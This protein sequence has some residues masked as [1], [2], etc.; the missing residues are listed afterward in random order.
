MLTYSVRSS[1]KVDEEKTLHSCMSAALQKSADYIDSLVCEEAVLPDNVFETSASLG[2]ECLNM[3]LFDELLKDMF[4]TVYLRSVLFASYKHVHAN[5]MH[6]KH[7]AIFDSSS[8]SLFPKF[9]YFCK[10]K[11]VSITSASMIMDGDF[12][13]FGVIASDAIQS[14]ISFINDLWRP[15][16]D[17]DRSAW[18]S[19]DYERMQEFFRARAST[20]DLLHQVVREGSSGIKL[21]FPD[22]SL[23]I[24]RIPVH[25]DA[26][27][28]ELQGI[29]IAMVASWC[30]QIDA[31][32]V[33]NEPFFHDSNFSP[34]EEILYWTTRFDVLSGIEEQLKARERRHCVMLIGIVENKPAN[35][36]VK[37]FRTAE[38]ALL[39]NLTEAL[40]TKSH[41]MPLKS[42]ACA[43]QHFSIRDIADNVPQLMELISLLALRCRRYGPGLPISSFIGKFSSSIERCIIVHL[44]DKFGNSSGMFWSR[45]ISE[46]MVR[47]VQSIACIDQYQEGVNAC[48]A[49]IHV[50]QVNVHSQAYSAASKAP[51]P[52]AIQEIVACQN[53]VE[54]K[55]ALLNLRSALSWQSLFANCFDLR[56]VSTLKFDFDN[57]DFASQ[58]LV[59]MEVD[60]LF[61]V[62]SNRLSLVMK[63]MIVAK[64]ALFDSCLR[65]INVEIQAQETVG[66]KIDVL[67]LYKE[68]LEQAG[69]AAKAMVESHSIV[70]VQVSDVACNLIFKRKTWVGIYGRASKSQN[71]L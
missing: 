65:Y 44:H 33:H 15:V 23:D 51:L 3:K 1:K 45:P 14:T 69:P 49:H 20:T 54:F 22:D 38:K 41:L 52:S 21:S 26:V 55:Q 68:I 60:D 6:Q 18:G 56:N 30:D 36:I 2:S 28:L 32:L 16:F 50:Q 59:S 7:L 66:S 31:A 17:L 70:I 71:V 67:D 43:F 27:N 46:N 29:L 25:R 57:F 12:V 5:R 63:S 10:L 13:F 64:D 61:N 4:P 53:L 24:D 58:K 37:R 19:L 42:I 47:L 40:D 39:D 9:V 35:A 11:N 62:H 8:R 48:R 34:S